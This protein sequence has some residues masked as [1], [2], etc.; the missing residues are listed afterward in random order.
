MG[1]RPLQR[2]NQKKRPTP[3]LPHPAV[4]HSQVFSTSQRF[5]PLLAVPALF[6]AGSTHGVF[7]PSERSPC[8]NRFAFRLT[9]PS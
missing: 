6:H 4:L 5:L 8:W 3:G 2:V 7:Y 9:F 1:F